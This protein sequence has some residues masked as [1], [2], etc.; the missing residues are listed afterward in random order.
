RVI[1]RIL[2]WDFDRVTVTHG[3][4]LESGGRAKLEQA[5]AWL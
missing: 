5:F 3:Q 1:D 2:E 4:V